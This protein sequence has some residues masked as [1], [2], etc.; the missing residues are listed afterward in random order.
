MATQTSLDLGMDA[1]DETAST[2][3]HRALIEQLVPVAQELARVRPEGITVSELRHEAVRRQILPAS[4]PGRALS[5]LGAVMRAAK[6]IA[7]NQ[8]RRSD[9]PKSHGNAHRVWVRP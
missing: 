8:W 9:I 5:F 6:L 3:D 4:A 2:A 1:L 7:T